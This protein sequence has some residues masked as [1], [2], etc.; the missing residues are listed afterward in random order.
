MQTP[1]SLE[2]QSVV[3]V[4]T[5]FGRG[6]KS[7]SKLQKKVATE[8][9]LN[10]LSPDDIAKNTEGVLAAGNRKVKQSCGLGTSIGLRGRKGRNIVDIRW[11][12]KWQEG[13]KTDEKF[14]KS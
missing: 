11:V 14:V 6:C 4:E 1:P 5:Y 12:R 8:K 13:P 3:L 9:E 10:N 7:K 2:S